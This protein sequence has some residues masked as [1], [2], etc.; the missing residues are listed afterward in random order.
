MLR[1]SE[2]SYEI[3]PVLN[4]FLIHIGLNLLLHQILHED[5]HFVDSIF[6]EQ[7]LVSDVKTEEVSQFVADF[8]DD[9][10]P[11]S[12]ESDGHVVIEKHLLLLKLTQSHWQHAC[13]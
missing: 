5:H 11:P 3:N 13:V 4:A 8:L 1:R 12:V 7:L 2:G 6:N 10:A 9:A